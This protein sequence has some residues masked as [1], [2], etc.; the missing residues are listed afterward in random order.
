ML[1]VTDFFR[2]IGLGAGEISVW[3]PRIARGKQTARL[4]YPLTV[5]FPGMVPVR[6]PF[7]FQLQMLDGLFRTDLSCEQLTGQHAQTD[8]AKAFDPTFLDLP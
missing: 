7:C 3:L 1:W 2:P 6:A 4:D 8:P 5:V